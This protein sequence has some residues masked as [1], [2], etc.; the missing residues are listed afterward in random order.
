VGAVLGLE[1]IADAVFLG[2]F[3]LRERDKEEAKEALGMDPSA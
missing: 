2:A 3:A 1:L